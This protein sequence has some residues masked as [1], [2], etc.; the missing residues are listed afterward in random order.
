MLTVYKLVAAALVLVFIFSG[1]AYAQLRAYG[2]RQNDNS[3]KLLYVTNPSDSI[4]YVAGLKQTDLKDCLSFSPS[5]IQGAPYRID[6]STNENDYLLLLP[7]D[8]I[9]YKILL[10]TEDNSKEKELS[11]FVR[12]SPDVIATNND[13][14]RNKQISRLRGWRINLDVIE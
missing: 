6:L 13:K 9:A 14:K 4:F 7:K 3:C 11:L 12:I 10:S 5:N 1:D 8:T 2:G